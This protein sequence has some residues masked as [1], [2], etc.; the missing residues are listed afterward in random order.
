M[1]PDEAIL[2]EVIQSALEKKDVSILTVFKNKGF[3]CNP[4]ELFRNAKGHVDILI[5]CIESDLID[6]G[7][8]TKESNKNLLFFVIESKPLIEALLKKRSKCKSCG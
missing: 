8:R 3:E 4:E 7:Y 5:K 6:L 2:E 1:I